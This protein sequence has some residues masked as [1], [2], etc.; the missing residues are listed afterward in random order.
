MGDVVGGVI[1]PA[2]DGAIHGII[3][4]LLWQILNTISIQWPYAIITGH[5]TKLIVFVINPK[6]TRTVSRVAGGSCELPHC[7]IRAD[8][9]FEYCIP[10]FVL[11]G[12]GGEV[13]DG[14]I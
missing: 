4:S 2:L 7:T 9:L 14:P 12:C 13:V 3:H 8:V 5:K 1:R 6:H 10:Y 11:D